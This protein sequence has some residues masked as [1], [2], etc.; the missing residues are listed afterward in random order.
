ML[1]EKQMDKIDVIHTYTHTHTH[2]EATMEYYSAVKEGNSAVCD[3]VD[4]P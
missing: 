2:T 4:R 1:I 3:Y